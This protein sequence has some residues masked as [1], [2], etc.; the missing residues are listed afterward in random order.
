[1]EIRPENSAGVN[2]VV[3]RG[4][5]GAPHGRRRAVR[6][7]S[8]RAAGPFPAEPFPKGRA[9]FPG[10]CAGAGP[11]G[12][13]GALREGPGGGTGSS[14]GPGPGPGNTERSADRSGVC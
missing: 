10:R 7:A 8:R 1:M 11:V 5:R 9:R 2:G 12:G 3:K 14:P 13:P 4:E 6:N